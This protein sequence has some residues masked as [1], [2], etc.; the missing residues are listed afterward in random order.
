MYVGVDAVSGLTL[1]LNLTTEM[2][3]LRLRQIWRPLNGYELMF[4]ANAHGN[5][6]NTINQ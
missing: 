6:S 1:Y 3:L 4:G 5:E 2:F